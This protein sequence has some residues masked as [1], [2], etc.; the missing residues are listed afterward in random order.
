MIYFLHP[1]QPFVRRRLGIQSPLKEGC[2]TLCGRI[3]PASSR[4]WQ[5]SQVAFSPWRR[6]LKR[7]RGWAR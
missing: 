7:E 6:L 1:Q 2:F 4:L 3:Q 5:I